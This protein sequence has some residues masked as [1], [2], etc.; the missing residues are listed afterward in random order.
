MRQRKTHC[1]EFSSDEQAAAL[2]GQRRIRQDV[3]IAEEQ[4]SKQYWYT[5]SFGARR[6]VEELDVRMGAHMGSSK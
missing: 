2:Q 6:M 5:C 4:T 1:I 3:L